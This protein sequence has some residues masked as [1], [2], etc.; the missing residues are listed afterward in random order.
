MK[1][2]S[3]VLSC[4]LWPSTV[5]FLQHHATISS[6][7]AFF[8]RQ[9][10]HLELFRKTKL[11][12]ENNEPSNNSLASVLSPLFRRLDTIEAAGLENVRTAGVGGKISS[13]VGKVKSLPSDV[14]NLT[15][16]DVKPIK[17]IKGLHGPITYL[18]LAVVMANKYK[19]LWKNPAWWFG[20]AFCVKWFRARY[21]FKIPVWDRQPNW[22]NVI[23]SKEQEKDLKA[24]TCK[25]CGSTIFIAKTREFFFEGSTGIGGLGCFSCGAKGADNFVMDRDRIVEDVADMDDYFEYE[26]PLDFISRA[27][28]RKLMKEAGGDEEKANQLLVDRSNA[29]AS[30]ESQAKAE[31]I[32]NGGKVEEPSIDAEIVDEEVDQEDDSSEEAEPEEEDVASTEETPAVEAKVEEEPKASVEETPTPPPS[33]PQKK[34]VKKSSAPPAPPSGDDDDI[35]DLL[36]MD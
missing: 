19:N 29:Q 6:P 12:L 8:A 17:R 36:D 28:R 2:P 34:T 21:I 25:T 24:F 15:W 3:I 16:K 33:E 23:T 30:D 27:E 1:F 7:S 13:L 14:K 20:V 31:A 9:A 10:S 22:N 32:V 4:L 26:R 35:F 11:P 18:V 5:G